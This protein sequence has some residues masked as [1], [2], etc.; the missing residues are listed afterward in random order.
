MQYV[1][2]CIAL[3][4]AIALEPEQLL[5]VCRFK[6]IHVKCRNESSKIK[7]EALIALRLTVL[8][9]ASPLQYSLDEKMNYFGKEKK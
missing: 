2:W 7:I 3:K 6:S 5:S 4:Q 8:A 9:C 1:T